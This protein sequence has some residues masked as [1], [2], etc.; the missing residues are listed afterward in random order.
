L[1]DEDV[2]LAL[3]LL[4]VPVLVYSSTKGGVG[5]VLDG[6]V[7]PL[8]EGLVRAEEVLL[9]A[10]EGSVGEEDRSGTKEAGVNGLSFAQGAENKWIGG[11]EVIP[12]VLGYYPSVHGRQLEMKE[13]GRVGVVGDPSFSRV[14]WELFK[15]AG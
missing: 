14:V 8:L 6:L 9:L 5:L 12:D 3:L 15:E 11:G 1:F 13:E 10:R 4:Q 7:N 2:K